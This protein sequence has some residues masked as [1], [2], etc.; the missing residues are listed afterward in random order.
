V[1]INRDQAR[2]A[3][4][5]L[6]EQFGELPELAGIGLTELNGEWAVKLNLTKPI[7]MALPSSI[8]GVA[9]WVEVVGQ[10]RAF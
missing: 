10:S 7:T 3:K 6:L 8:D 2:A 5:K 9:I 1:A 4:Q